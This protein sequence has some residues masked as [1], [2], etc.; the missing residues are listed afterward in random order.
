MTNLGRR[1]ISPS[2]GRACARQGRWLPRHHAAPE[3]PPFVRLWGERCTQKRRMLVFLQKGNEKQDN[4]T[5]WQK[6]NAPPNVRVAFSLMRRYVYVW[7]SLVSALLARVR[8][9][10]AARKTFSKKE[11]KWEGARACGIMARRVFWR[12]ME[13]Q[14]A[15][16]DFF[17]SFFSFFFLGSEQAPPKK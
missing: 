16:E 11:A 4:L 2:R 9:V 8:I 5:R 7:S 15:D 13:R 3:A 12:G 6:G 1:C 10:Q 17:F 14:T